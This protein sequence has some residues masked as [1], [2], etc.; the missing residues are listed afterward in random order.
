L[1]ETNPENSYFT[2]FNL[3]I[4]NFNPNYEIRRNKTYFNNNCYS[5]NINSNNY[6]NIILIIT[7]TISKTTTIKKISHASTIQDHSVITNIIKNVENHH[8]KTNNSVTT[9]NSITINNN[10]TINNS[11]T[12]NNSSNKRKIDSISTDKTK[13]NS[14]KKN[15]NEKLR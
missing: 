1:F 7:T 5:P 6:Y 2:R 15:S 8:I 3:N 4:S 14:K 10:I 13:T 11:I 9:N 12:T